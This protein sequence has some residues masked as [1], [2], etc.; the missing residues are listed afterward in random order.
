MDWLI[1]LKNKLFP[2]IPGPPASAEVI[3]EAKKQWMISLV[4]LFVLV[5][6]Y[7]NKLK[8]KIKRVLR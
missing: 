7:G 3:D 6:L 5:K 8:Y 4:V 1:D 2:E